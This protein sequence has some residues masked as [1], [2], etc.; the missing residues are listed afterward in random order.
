MGSVRFWSRGAHF[1]LFWC[2]DSP[3][4]LRN[5]LR[6]DLLAESRS[7]CCFDKWAALDFVFFLLPNWWLKNGERSILSMVIKRP[8]WKLAKIFRTLRAQRHDDYYAN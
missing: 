4:G 1:A 5:S 6:V 3:A 2:F 7:S 8:V